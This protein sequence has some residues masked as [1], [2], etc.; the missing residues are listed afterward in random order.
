MNSRAYFSNPDLN[1]FSSGQ[2]DEKIRLI[3]EERLSPQLR[4][5]YDHSSFYRR[6]FDEVGAK[7]EDIKTL[8]N[9]RALPIFMDKDQERKNAIESLE[10]EGHPFGTHLC[11]PVDEIYLVG[12]TS[13][14]TGTPTFSYTFTKKDVELIA[15]GLG[16]R[17]AYNGVK[18]GDRILFFFALGIYA[19]T[20]SLWGIR[21]IGALPI[22][23]D[24]RAGSE[25]MLSFAELTKPS[26]M[27]TTVSL[28]EYLINKAPDVLGKEVLDLKLKGLM[29]TGEIGVNI[30][31]V[32]NHLEEA[33]GCPVYD[34]WA[35]AGHAIAI[36]CRAEQYSGMHGISPD[37]CTGF[38]DLV[39]PDS[40]EPIPIEDGA[41]GEIVVTSLKREALPLIRYAMGDI[42]QIFTKP[43]P[44]CG[45]PGKRIKLI[46]RSDDMLIVKGVNVYPFAIKKVV[47]SFIPRV[48]GEMRIV[49][50]QK[51]P[52]VTP[53]LKL[54]LEHSFDIRNPELDGLA[55]EISRA[56]HDKLKIRPSIYWVAPGELEKSTSKT[57]IFEKNY[58]VRPK[59]G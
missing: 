37:L 52:K 31:E 49:L 59:S 11:A 17:F 19:T 38:E 32:K 27:A 22:D 6:K 9:L 50:D 21:N 39:N 4:Y 54:K 14:T 13:G 47:E 36:T 53:P 42:A 18:K 24:S 55:G 12:T 1:L 46:G 34:Y 41:T 29:L 33:Y 25:L 7:P 20:M 58:E 8:E 51:P 2:I 44:Y 43:C 45:F 40:K 30:P 28:A 23:I 10:T 48:T 3:Q 56:L 5:C 16:H 15:E 35:P 26:Y 57:P